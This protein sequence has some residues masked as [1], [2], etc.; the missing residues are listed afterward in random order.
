[1]LNAEEKIEQVRVGY[2]GWLGKAADKMACEQI[3]VAVGV[4]KRIR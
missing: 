2:V 3:G 4:G 1:M